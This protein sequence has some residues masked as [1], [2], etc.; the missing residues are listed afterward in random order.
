M[1]NVSLVPIFLLCCAL[2]AEVYD[3]ET[4]PDTGEWFERVQ[5]RI[6][7]PDEVDNVRAIY[8]Y[9]NPLR[10]DSR[11]IVWDQGFRQLC[12]DEGIAV[13]GARLDNLDMAS[14]VGDA[15]LRGLADFSLQS[16]HAEIKNLPIYFD[17][18]SWGGQFGY[19]FTLWKPARTLGFITIKG[20]VHDTRFAGDAIE[21]PGYMVIGELDLPYRLTN[22]TGIFE[23]HRPLGAKWI[24]ALEPGA[25]A[26]PAS[27][28]V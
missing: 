7:W 10:S 21:V 24:L 14:G 16:G 20:G 12:A 13:M 4:G 11:F 27:A 3:F 28:P 6:Y 9:V 15:L 5:A 2:Q 25:D 17:G 8:F 19:H 22:L 18:H 26:A 1:R 23:T